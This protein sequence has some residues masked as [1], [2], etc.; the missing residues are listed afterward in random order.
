MKFSILK[1]KEENFTVNLKLNSFYYSATGWINAKALYSLLCEMKGF[2]E[3]TKYFALVL[4]LQLKC[5]F[6]LSCILFTKIPDLIDLETNK[7]WIN[8]CTYMNIH[9]CIVLHLY[10]V[11]HTLSFIV[12]SNHANI[13][14]RIRTIIHNIIKFRPDYYCYLTCSICI[15]DPIC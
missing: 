8:E 14:I 10:F 4:R 11:L 9:K 7:S 2:V 15:I 6:C 12:S 5:I 3:P 1:E 13:R